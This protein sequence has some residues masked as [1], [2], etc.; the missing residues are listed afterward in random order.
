MKSLLNAAYLAAS[1][2]RW[3][4]DTDPAECDRLTLEV[5][6]YVTEVRRLRGWKKRPGETNR[7]R[8]AYPEEHTMDRKTCRRM[9]GEA[10]RLQLQLDEYVETL[11][12]EAAK[13]C[14]GPSVQPACSEEDPCAPC[15]ARTRFEGFNR[16]EGRPEG[17]D[18]T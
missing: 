14:R 4:T 17:S 15:F 1:L 6:E 18:A 11:R 8:T 13:P 12:L 10:G 16:T 2:A 3:K 7:A 5:L 9:A